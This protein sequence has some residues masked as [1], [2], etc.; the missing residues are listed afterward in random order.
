MIEAEGIV[1]RAVVGCGH[2]ARRHDATEVDDVFLGGV[3]GVCWICSD[4]GIFADFTFSSSPHYTSISF[5]DGSTP[6]MIGS[7]ES[8]D[9]T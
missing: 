4:K 7:T 1:M 3:G 9:V 2:R 8:A 6:I 5:I